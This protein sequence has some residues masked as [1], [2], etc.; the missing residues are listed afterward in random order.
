MNLE[1][2]YT[3][4]NTKH[5]SQGEKIAREVLT[6]VAKQTAQSY[7]TKYAIKGAEHLIKLA[8]KGAVGAGKHALT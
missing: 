8:A 5:H 6:N 3:Q 7:A 2:Q 1:K 4:L